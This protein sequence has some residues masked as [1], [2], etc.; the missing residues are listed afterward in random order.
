MTKGNENKQWRFSLY[1]EAIPLVL[2][3]FTALFL[4]TP[5]FTGNQ[6]SKQT[7]F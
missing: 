5:V 1:N 2:S 3:L 6:A 4:A 7:A